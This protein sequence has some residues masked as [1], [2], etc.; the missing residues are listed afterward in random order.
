MILSHILSC[1]SPFCS[2][3]RKLLRTLGI[4]SNIVRNTNGTIF[5]SKVSISPGRILLRYFNFHTINSPS[6]LDHQKCRFHKALR[7]HQPLYRRGFEI[8]SVSFRTRY[9]LR[10]A[11]LNNQR[12]Y[13]TKIL[14]DCNKQIVIN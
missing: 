7:A 4:K 1:Q 2:F 11:L 12:Y 6:D 10:G 5:L 3:V 8:S 9:L 13:S 14:F